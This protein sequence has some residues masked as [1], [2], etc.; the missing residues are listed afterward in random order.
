MSIDFEAPPAIF[1]SFRLRVTAA[2]HC[3]AH[4]AMSASLGAAAAF[5]CR[6]PGAPRRA[7]SARRALRAAAPRASAEKAANADGLY[8]GTLLFH[9]YPQLTAPKPIFST[10]LEGALHCAEVAKSH[11][12]YQTAH[13]HEAF[14]AERAVNEQPHAYLGMSVFSC[15]PETLW[16]DFEDFKDC[17]DIGHMDQEHHPLV[18]R[19]SAAFPGPESALAGA[20]HGAVRF[21][22]TDAVVVVA[23]AADAAAAGA[24]TEWSGAALADKECGDAFLGATLH[25]V[26]EAARY[27]HVARVELGNV[28]DAIVRS[29]VEEAT[30]KVTAMGVEDFVIEPYRCAFNIEKTGTPAGAL[31]AVRE[32]QKKQRENE[33]EKAAFDANEGE[34]TDRAASA[35]RAVKSAEV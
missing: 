35:K 22:E 15:A 20:P 16:S 18:C 31:P 23:V 19:E 34:E 4:T 6:A 1:L 30:A 2:G 17:L 29:V 27:T 12:S 8:D 3:S 21:A 33:K 25:E 11:P 7:R 26:V 13:F 9:V 32:M 28:P 14:D 5:R 10:F 24:W